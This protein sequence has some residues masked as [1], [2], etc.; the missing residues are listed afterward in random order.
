MAWVSLEKADSVSPV[1]GA[2]RTGMS[3]LG[4][5]EGKNQVIDAWWGDGSVVRLEQQRG[6]ILA[7]R[8]DLIVAQGG[9][10]CSTSWAMRVRVASKR[11][12]WCATS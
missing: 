10:R 3:A 6:A 7:A 4:Y 1:F 2:F 5:V 11:W 8:P 12:L 9:M